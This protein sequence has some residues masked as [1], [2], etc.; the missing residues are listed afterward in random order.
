MKKLNVWALVS[1]Y[2]IV[3]K[4]YKTKA[5]ALKDFKKNAG[6]S[7]FNYHLDKIKIVTNDK[8]LI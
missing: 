1:Q 8:N 3:T 5:A 2:Y 7:R 6:G 4:L